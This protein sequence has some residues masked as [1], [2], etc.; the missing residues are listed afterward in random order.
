MSHASS[1]PSI[2]CT[3][4]DVDVIVGDESSSGWLCAC[5]RACVRACAV[6]CDRFGLA[7][8]TL[9]VEVGGPVVAPPPALPV[10]G[11]SEPGAAVPAVGT[12]AADASTD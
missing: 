12:A 9:P 6:L 7:A 11:E 2:R 4:A 1:I 3:F 8:D 10:V 5:V